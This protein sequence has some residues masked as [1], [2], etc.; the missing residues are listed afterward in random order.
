[1]VITPVVILGAQRRAKKQGKVQQVTASNGLS[2]RVS[3]TGSASWYLRRRIEGKLVQKLL[4][5]Y[6]EMSYRQAAEAAAAAAD[7]IAFKPT[8][9]TIT[10]GEI[11]EAWKAK[12]SQEIS[13]WENV[14]LRARKHIL[15]KFANVPM[16]DLTAPMLIRYWEPLQQEGRMETIK[17]MCTVVRQLAEFAVNTGRVETIHELTRV[18][19]NYH[20]PK[21]QH[22]ASLD[23][24]FL[25]EFWKEL[26][27]YNVRESLTF[28]LLLASFYTLVRQRELTSLRWDWI[29]RERAIITFPA[30]VMKMRR[31]HVCPI[32]TQMGALLDVIT[33]AGPFVFPSTRFL[34]EPANSEQ[35]RCFLTKH[36]FSGRL[37]AHGI[38]AI[39]RTWM[40]KQ[41]V[42]EHVAE[43]CLSHSP[44]TAVVKA[45][46]HY[47]YLEERRVVM[48]Q[49]CDYVEKTKDTA[50]QLL[51]NE[52]QGKTNP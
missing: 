28:R 12:K 44:G 1:M 15:K 4:G 46:Q 24:D 11:F 2:L 45:Y 39:G 6:P 27:A 5:N 25:T 23:P 10:V 19:A 52:L 3:P 47:D 20:F 14:E 22:N 43:A 8:T 33:P 36:G 51:R 21:P 48:Q 32:T 9:E 7:E 41:D 40:A 38:R 49:W 29:D 30:A 18:A 37:T 17:K 13:S 16:K 42:P 34:N 35:V 26:L 31:A 50:S